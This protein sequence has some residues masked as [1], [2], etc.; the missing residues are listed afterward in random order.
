MS[1]DT[2]CPEA[3]RSRLNKILEI[4]LKTAQMVLRCGVGPNKHPAIPVSRFF[5]HYATLFCQFHVDGNFNVIR[6]A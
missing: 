4:L 2:F 3:E 6:H 5:L 1:I